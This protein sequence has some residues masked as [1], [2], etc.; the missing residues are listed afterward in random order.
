MEWWKG[1]TLIDFTNQKTTEIQAEINKIK[2]ADLNNQDCKINI[3]L[4]KSNFVWEHQ[5]WKYK[6]TCALK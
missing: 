6:K 1:G 3:N 2:S 4:N 5:F